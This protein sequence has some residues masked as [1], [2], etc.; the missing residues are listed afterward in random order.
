MDP[1]FLLGVCDAVGIGHE[2]VICVDLQHGG[3]R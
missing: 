2:Q 1:D 3:T